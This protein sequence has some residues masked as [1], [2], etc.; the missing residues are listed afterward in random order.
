M[1]TIVTDVRPLFTRLLP[2]G[3]DELPYRL[4]DALLLYAEGNPAFVT[5]IAEAINDGNEVRPFPVCYLLRLC[6][7]M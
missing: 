4:V 1:D 3:S 6:Y 7:P 5:L 2:G